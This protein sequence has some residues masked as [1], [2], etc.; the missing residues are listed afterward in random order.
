MCDCSCTRVRVSSNC[1]RPRTDERGV[2]VPAGNSVTIESGEVGEVGGEGSSDE[3]P[4]GDDE[5]PI[6]DQPDEG[7]EDFNE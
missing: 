3:D 7:D 4:E 1:H 2:N 6:Y 5:E